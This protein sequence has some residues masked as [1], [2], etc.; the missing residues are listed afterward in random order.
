MTVFVFF[1]LFIM[2]SYLRTHHQN[3]SKRLSALH[4]EDEL[5]RRKGL[6][7]IRVMM[8]KKRMMKQ[9]KKII[10]PRLN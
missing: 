6:K 8:M 2:W 9:M 3:Y 7:I 1:S 4:D 5:K 10:T